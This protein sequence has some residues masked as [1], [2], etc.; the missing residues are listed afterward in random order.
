MW[1]N[2]SELFLWLVYPVWAFVSLIASEL[3]M[4]I[5]VRTMPWM[6]P[7]NSMLLQLVED[8]Q[9]YCLA[10]M[11]ALLPVIIWRSAWLHQAGKILRRGLR[12]LLGWMRRPRLMDVIDATLGCAAY[13]VITI[14]LA[15]VAERVIPWYDVS[16]VQDV[17]FTSSALTSWFYWVIGFAVL[18]IVPPIMEETLF[19][20]FVFGELRRKY[21]FIWS[22]LI[23][24]LLFGFAHMA[25]NVGVDTFA[26]SLV[27][28]YLRESTGSIWASVALHMIKN[29][30]AFYVLFMAQ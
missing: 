19:R 24:S 9:I 27:L 29:G 30:I 10:L 11:V 18:V 7:R 23:T 6:Y 26:L 28:C 12:E 13:L 3:A 8:A 22:T 16:Q 21:G 15:Y 5:V 25:W 14:A 4:E 20:G 2:F 1:R 17:G